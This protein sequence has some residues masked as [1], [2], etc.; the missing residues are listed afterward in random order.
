MKTIY[1]WRPEKTYP[2]PSKQKILKLASAAAEVTG[3]GICRSLSLSCVSESEMAEINQSYV[4]HQGSTDVICFD[5]RQSLDELP[6][7]G[8]CC[9]DDVEVEIIICPAVAAREAAKR[10]LPYSRELTLYLVHGLLHA[11]GEDDL[12]P[13]LKRVMRRREAAALRQL[14]EKFDLDTI[15][16]IPVTKGEK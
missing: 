10:S 2:R 11:A 1:S 13:E 9:E 7:T 16:P 5:Y 14:S 15:F 3:S 6:E 8:E 12:K 4:G